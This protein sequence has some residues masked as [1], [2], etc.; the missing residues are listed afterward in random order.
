MGTYAEF[1]IDKELLS[2]YWP[3]RFRAAYA[4]IDLPSGRRQF[5]EAFG[6][7]IESVAKKL[8]SALSL[9][10]LHETTEIVEL[11]SQTKGK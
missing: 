7:E 6:H 10:S 1:K 4:S 11:A 8:P 2:F 9:K 3:D 5:F